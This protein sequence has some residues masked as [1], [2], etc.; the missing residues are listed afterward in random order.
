[1]VL[2]L[3]DKWVWDSW[4]AR[5]GPDYHIYYLQ[6]SRSLGEPELR[7]W[8]VSIGHAV[9]QDLRNWEIL[10]DALKPSAASGQWDNYTTW[11]GSVIQHG[12][13]WYL[14]YTGGSQRENGL[15]QRIGLATSTDLLHWVGHHPAADRLLLNLVDWGQCHE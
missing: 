9:S 13:L 6:A 7:H 14:F 1:M 5:Q 15:V 4:L 12:G 8:N 2:C 3:P 11:T 10:P